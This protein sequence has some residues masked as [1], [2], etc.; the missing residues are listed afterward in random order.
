MKKYIFNL[1]KVLFILLSV[2][3]I[4]SCDKD[5]DNTPTTWVASYSS[6]TIGAQN[7]YTYG[8][9][10]MSQT[11][12]VVAVENTSGQEAYLGLMFFTTES[13]ASTYLTFP[14]DGAEAG[15]SET[16]NSR[17]FTQDPGGID[18]WPAASIVS[19]MIN[20]CDLTSLEFDN[21][22]NSIT[23]A[24]FDETFRDQNND[25]EYLSYKKNYVLTPEAGEVYL[26]QFNGIVRAI[27]R[28]K[29]VVTAGTNGASITFDIIVEGRDAFSS[30]SGA[31]Y[32]QPLKTVNLR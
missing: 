8:H 27:I 20:K 7:N 16:S 15:T 26:A 5:E 12:G 9:F 21:L 29:T 25:A 6:V 18:T 23:W 2:V 4:T 28:V 24:L 13:G 1:T 11:G 17:L 14:G 22:K 3:F 30:S 31:K 10:F 19:G 32:L